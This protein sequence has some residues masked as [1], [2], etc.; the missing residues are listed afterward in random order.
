MGPAVPVMDWA[1]ARALMDLAGLL[2]LSSETFQGISW[3]EEGAREQFLAM[4][5]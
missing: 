3:M 2:P 4:S 1:Q 5:R